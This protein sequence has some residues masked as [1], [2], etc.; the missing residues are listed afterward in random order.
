M[1]RLLYAQSD[2]RIFAP[3]LRVRWSTWFL[4]TNTPLHRERPLVRMTAL[5]DL[6]V[7]VL[8]RDGARRGEAIEELSLAL[9]EMQEDQLDE[10]TS[11]MDVPGLDAQELVAARE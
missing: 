7:M 1:Q 6:I 10:Y 11:I 4:N 2:V 9:S 5:R 3:C 8:D